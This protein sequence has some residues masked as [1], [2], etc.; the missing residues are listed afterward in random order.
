[1]RHSH[2]R[3]FKNPK[4]QEKDGTKGKVTKREDLRIDES[5]RAAMPCTADLQSSHPGHRSRLAERRLE[6]FGFC[7]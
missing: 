7:R 3:G 1:M 5:K 6:T 4:V 2:E